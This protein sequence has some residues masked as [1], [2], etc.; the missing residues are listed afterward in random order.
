MAQARQVNVTRVPDNW[1]IAKDAFSC[2][3]VITH[4]S[5]SLSLAA[6]SIR[7]GKRPKRRDERRRN[8]RNVYYKMIF[9]HP[10]M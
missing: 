1:W 7:V 8:K 2:G 9:V 3:R 5:S 4:N 6:F 10:E